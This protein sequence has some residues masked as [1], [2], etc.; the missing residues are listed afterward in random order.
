MEGTSDMS[1]SKDPNQEK[2]VAS[3]VARMLDS[4]QFSP[5]DRGWLEQKL[6]ED[7]DALQE[8]LKLVDLDARLRWACRGGR[9]PIQV[10][11]SVVATTDGQTG[12]DG[13]TGVASAR[14][15][16]A[17]PFG[18][19]TSSAFEE[20]PARATKPLWHPYARSR[21]AKTYGLIATSVAV[22]LL[23]FFG[24]QL[25]A[26]RDVMGTLTQT[27]AA[28]WGE[29][30]IDIAPGEKIKPGQ[31]KLKAGVAEIT[32][33]DDTRLIIEGPSVF[34]VVSTGKAFLKR[35]NLSVF[36]GA[37]TT[38]FTVDTPDSRVV[39]L[40]TAFQVDVCHLG[41][42]VHVLEGEVVASRIRES[43]EAPEAEK[44]HLSN[45]DAIRFN[46][47]NP[48]IVPIEFVGE[49]L[50]LH[51]D[52]LLS[53]IPRAVTGDIRCLDRPPTS[54]A[55]G[56]YE[57][58]D[59]MFLFLEQSN[60][61]LERTIY[62]DRN[63]RGQ[64]ATLHGNQDMELTA[65]MRVTSYLLHFD[66]TTDRPDDPMNRVSGTVTFRSPIIAVFT[67]NVGLYESDKQLSS[68]LTRYVND[69]ETLGPRGLDALDFVSFSPN[70]KTL[71]VNLQANRAADQIRIITM[72]DLP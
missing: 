28:E 62:A 31:M 47:R 49:R 56:E 7:D 69:G 14:P 6:R 29:P 5:E 42:E 52:S 3:M 63:S 21:R 24:R 38:G 27:A 34:E 39:D 19:R 17:S 1:G 9:S 40:S 43:A 10:D 55:V 53:A 35:G 59:E 50:K 72:D 36:V 8:Y 65:G 16:G 51:G 4:E 11:R 67:S 54:I 20:S 41:T 58:D 60:A 15:A 37:E 66:P 46:R 33:R 68:E 25:V 12:S 22:L 45:R 2:T 57:H 64:V 44:I 71:I 48:R 18:Q 30:F 26:D 61:V 70:R 13:Q 32:L 23:V